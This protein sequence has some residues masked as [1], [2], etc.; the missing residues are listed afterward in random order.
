MNINSLFDKI[1]VLYIN[2]KELSRIKPKLL[3]NNITAH[4]FKGVDG[5]KETQLYQDYRKR[6]YEPNKTTFQLLTPGQ[7][8]HI[9]SFIKIIED[10]LQN[11]HE[12]ILI[13]ES[14]IYFSTKLEDRLKIVETFSWKLLYLGASQYMFYNEQTWDNIEIKEGYYHPN[15]TLGTFAVA[16]KKDFYVEYLK[17]LQKFNFTSDVCLV[18]LQ[19]KYYEDSYVIYPN[20]ICCD[21]STSSTSTRIN[22]VIQT[23]FIKKYRWTDEYDFSDYYLIKDLLPNKVYELVLTI[24]SKLDNIKLILLDKDHE[25]QFKQKEVLNKIILT[26]VPKTNELALLTN[27]IFVESV[28]RQQVVL[29]NKKK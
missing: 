6:I 4:Y 15:K 24:N 27:N 29:S 17:N 7:F 8:G 28:D 13:L 14:D 22:K 5:K 3:R 2:E 16:F 18:N 21:L 12:S 25:I 23:D 11:K 10:A 20:P 26:F 19:G 9:S 1:Y